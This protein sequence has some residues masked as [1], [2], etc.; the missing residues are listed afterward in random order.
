MRAEAL[1]GRYSVGEE[2]THTIT[3]G[4]GLLLSI[5]GLAVL[6]VFASVRGDAWHIVGCSC[7]SRKLIAQ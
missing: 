2:I 6:V 5:A 4:L 7:G 1:S 3:H